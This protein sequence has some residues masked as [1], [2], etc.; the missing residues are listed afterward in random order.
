[1][2]Q[3]FAPLLP[4]PFVTVGPDTYTHD[5]LKTAGG[6]NVFTHKTPQGDPNT[7]AEDATRYPLVTTDEVEAAQPEVVLL[8]AYP[9]A[10]TDDH[11]AWFGKLDIPAAKSKQIYLIDGAF[12]TYHGTRLAR[13][14]NQISELMYP[15]EDI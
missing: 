6:T 11:V 12:L 4:D 5:L 15:P 8:P 13:A 14:L 1:V 10:F 2:R 9:L 7:P 3:V